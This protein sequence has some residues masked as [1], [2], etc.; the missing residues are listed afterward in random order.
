MKPNAGKQR[1]PEFSCSPS[2]AESTSFLTV[3][4]EL[5]GLGQGSALVSQNAVTVSW[6]PLHKTFSDGGDAFFSVEQGK[7]LCD[8]VTT[9]ND[10]E[11]FRGDERLFRRPETKRGR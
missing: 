9:P 11:Y 3:F 1:S 8:P 10:D 2:R 7:Y 5:S 4:D 6:L